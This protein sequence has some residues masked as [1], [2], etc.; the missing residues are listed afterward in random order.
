MQEGLE[1]CEATEA[2]FPVPAIEQGMAG[3]LA[4]AMQLKEFWSSD[5]SLESFW[6]ECCPPHG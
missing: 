1:I 6:D 4:P 2:V 5:Y 3:A